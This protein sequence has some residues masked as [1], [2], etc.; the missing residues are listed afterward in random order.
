MPI[1]DEIILNQRSTY[2]LPTKAGLLLALIILLMMVAATNYQ[3]NLAF[4]LT[5]LISSIGIVSIVFT[6]KNLQGLKFNLRNNNPVFVGETLYLNFDVSSQQ[7]NPHSG[8]AVGF[9]KYA[10]FYLDI[11]SQSNRRAFKPFF[12]LPYLT[13]K[14]GE[15]ILPQIYTTSCFPF[16]LFKVW[17]WFQFKSSVLIYPN[18]ISP[19][20]SAYRNSSNTE[21]DESSQSRSIDDTEFDGIKEYKLGDP[22]SRVDWKATAKERGMYI[23]SFVNLNGADRAF[24]WN[25]FVNA[26]DELRLSYL[27]FL[28]C[29]A[30]NK[31][32]TYSL[33]IPGYSVSN[34]SGSEHLHKCLSILAMYPNAGFSN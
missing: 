28:I 21:G 11:L 22:I 27:C 24:D 33:T 12:S 19:P 6:F 1:A 13:E 17:S 4:M 31:N 2:I 15:L 23:K 5:F 26:S 16:G 18:P 32:E 7:E 14:R 9:D 8:I 34:N 29:D 3:N 25:D 10:L 30:G 20:D